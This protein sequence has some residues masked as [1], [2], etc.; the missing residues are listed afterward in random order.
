MCARASPFTC[1]PTYPPA[2]GTAPRYLVEHQGHSFLLGCVPLFELLPGE[3]LGQR[4]H[5]VLHVQDAAPLLVDVR[6]I[7]NE[8]LKAVNGKSTCTAQLALESPGDDIFAGREERKANPPLSRRSISLAGVPTA[9]P[10]RFDFR[11]ATDSSILMC[12]ANC[13]R[14]SRQPSA[15]G[16]LG[17]LPE[18]LGVLT[19][20]ATALSLV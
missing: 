4:H 12:F 10:T 13:P 18:V 1:L 3:Q 8:T 11:K 16:H 6:G 2:Q 9:M 7:D 19:S 20:F 17:H 15:A 5:R 14:V